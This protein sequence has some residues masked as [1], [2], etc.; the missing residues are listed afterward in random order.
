MAK[1]SITQT[2]N[3]G[4]FSE[5]RFTP[6]DFDLS[7]TDLAGLSP[8]SFSAR[9][10]RQGE[11][12]DNRNFSSRSF[13]NKQKEFAKKVA[14]LQ[15][16]ADEA[17]RNEARGLRAGDYVAP[18]SPPESETE[19]VTAEI[20]V[21]SPAQ[22]VTVSKEEFDSMSG[23]SK[24][25]ASRIEDLESV[26]DDYPF[27]FDENVEATATTL[28]LR[29]A[30]SLT[31]P[32]VLHVGEGCWTRRE[33]MTSVS[34]IM[35]YAGG[36]MS[37]PTGGVGTYYFYA[38]LS[39]YDDVHAGLIPT[40]ITVQI[41]D[42]PN[43]KPG[44]VG[45]AQE[46]FDYNIVVVLGEAEWDGAAWTSYQQYLYSDIDD[47]ADV[48][49]T[50]MGAGVSSLRWSQVDKSLTMY[51]LDVIGSVPPKDAGPGDTSYC[52]CLFGNTALAA[53]PPQ[54]VLGWYAI[55]GMTSL[56]A[57]SSIDS[58]AD[59]GW[60]FLEISGFHD[61]ASEAM[62][63]ADLILFKDADVNDV[64]YANADSLWD[65]IIANATD[66][67]GD[68]K[69]ALLDKSAPY[70]ESEYVLN[71]DH[72]WRYPVKGSAY[73]DADSDGAW[74]QSIGRGSVIGDGSAPPS[75][76][77]EAIDLTSSALV[78][79]S[80]NNDTLDWNAR[81]LKYDHWTVEDT[82][83]ALT[84]GSGCLRL[85]GGMSAAAP[86]HVTNLTSD[87]IALGNTA[88]AILDI[89]STGGATCFHAINGAIQASLA[90]TLTG[91][92]GRFTD[93]TNVFDICG[94]AYAA[95][96][97]TGGINVNSSSAYSWG[98]VAGTTRASDCNLVADDGT[99]IPVT[100][101]GGLIHVT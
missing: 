23:L 49:D 26:E 63:T 47:F 28:G 64:G 91:F 55:D 5:G 72:D 38:K 19:L 42:V 53:N 29:W 66:P 41:H 50:N 7:K 83:A 51:G 87:V 77:T 75:G 76:V 99:L 44:E 24:S 68:I 11:S 101:M 14:E 3:R 35:E 93:G 39:G 95:N 94:S 81:E 89:T 90:S 2:I 56:T 1:R 43:V 84:A 86:C 74:F 57:N 65:W 97:T 12:Q 70:T 27:D 46:Q 25:N 80:G 21:P 78:D 67:S 88:V 61:A 33:D 60:N 48:P 96:A 59:G 18:P 9:F 6:G 79:G 40:S 85:A 54:G 15:K 58:F 17:K 82:E 8:N 92:A 62:A 45:E 20:E 73:D 37:T 22:A 16:A 52:A 98:G 32:T 31:S 30:F 10:A 13:V 4:K 69:H 36:N 100:L 71:E 34:N